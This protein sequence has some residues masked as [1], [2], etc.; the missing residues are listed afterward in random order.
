MGKLVSYLG[1]FKEGEEFTGLHMLVLGLGLAVPLG[2]F[3]WL[4]REVLRAVYAT[5]W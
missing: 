4:M 2:G 3:F 5:F 1:R